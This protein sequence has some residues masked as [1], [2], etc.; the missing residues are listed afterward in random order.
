MG[1]FSATWL[2]VAVAV[3]VVVPAVECNHVRENLPHFL[4]VA[5][6]LLLTPY[7][8]LPHPL[9]RPARYC[10][11][12]LLGFYWASGRLPRV[13]A[14]TATVNRFGWMTASVRFHH[15]PQATSSF[16]VCPPA[17]PPP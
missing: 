7:I 6:A 10:C 8:R 16:C 5:H 1:M 14:S 9:T 3:A 15:L 11:M 2:L 17:R 13:T 4:D 12:H